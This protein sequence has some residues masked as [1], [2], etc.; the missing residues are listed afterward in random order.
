V[1]W[2]LIF[3]SPVVLGLAGMV[4]LAVANTRGRDQRDAARCYF[5]AGAGAFIGGLASFLAIAVEVDGQLGGTV[6]LVVF[7]VLTIVWV[8]GWLIAA[9]RAAATAPVERVG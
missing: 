6:L 5:S 4:L 8:A 2:F 9:H 1:T 3:L 7:P